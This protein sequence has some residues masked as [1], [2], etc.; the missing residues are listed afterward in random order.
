MKPSELVA[1][2]LVGEVEEVEPQRF[3]VAID[4][5]EE[6]FGICSVRVVADSADEA[7]RL[8]VDWIASLVWYGRRIERAR[9]KL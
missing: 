7:K 8:A 3:D 6:H 9:S 1:R 5:E 2:S 4:D